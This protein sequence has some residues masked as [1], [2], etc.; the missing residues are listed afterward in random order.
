[1]SGIRMSEVGQASS[2]G[3]LSHHQS[4]SH[5]LHQQQQQQLLQLNHLQAQRRGPPSMPRP[6]SSQR[7]PENI[8]QT[9]RPTDKNSVRQ[10]ATVN[11]RHLPPPSG[12]PPSSA[13]HRPYH[14]S[15]QGSNVGQRSAGSPNLLYVQQQQQQQTQQMSNSFGVPDVALPSSASS[16]LKQASKNLPKLSSVDVSLSYYFVYVSLIKSRCQKPISELHNLFYNELM[17]SNWL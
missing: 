5:H 11:P 1:M 3:R 12:L 15:P 16:R 7:L 2:M 6:P 14:V 10:P 13:H 4:N 17:P 9:H 8:N